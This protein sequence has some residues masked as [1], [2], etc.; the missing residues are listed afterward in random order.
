MPPLI[1]GLS[2]YYHDSAAA[3]VRGGEVVAAAQEER[4]S[5]VKHDERFPAQAMDYC[6][7]EAGVAAGELD[8]VVF[9]E[10]PLLKFDRVL[11]TFVARAPT[12][13]G[14]F[15]RGVPGWLK[16][17]LHLPRE[18]RKALG[19]EFRKR[20]AF[21]RHHEA[22]AACAFFPSPFEEAAILTMDGVGEWETASIG[23]GR[24]KKIDLLRTMHFPHSLGLL[25]SAFTSFCGFRVNSGEYKLMGLAP[26][27]EPR[28]AGVIRERLLDLKEDGSFRLDLR[29]FSTLR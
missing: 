16:T 21:T 6:L 18:I 12:G 28:F 17:K 22:H 24:G 19:G 3:L 4:F 13:I 11:E 2:A 5:R 27:G 29:Y 15:L 26:Y 25:Y 23:H 1:L 14:S 10:K 8:Y 9:Y 20:I 7:R